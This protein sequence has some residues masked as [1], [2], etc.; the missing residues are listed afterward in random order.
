MVYGLDGEDKLFGGGNQNI[1]I[2]GSVDANMDTFVEVFQIWNRTDLTYVEPVR[3][4]GGPQRLGDGWS[5]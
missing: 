5:R 3:Q 2:T 1:L 4:L